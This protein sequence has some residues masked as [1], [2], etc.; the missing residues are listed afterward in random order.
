MVA[1]E[2]KAVA[3]LP[4]AEERR[5]DDGAAAGRGKRGREGIWVWLSV[6][7]ESEAVG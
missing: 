1:E 4:S 7:W 6:V 5:S 3:M 2:R